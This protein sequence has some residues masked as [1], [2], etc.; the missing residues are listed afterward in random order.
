MSASE[1]STDLPGFEFVIAVASLGGLPV[2]TSLVRGL[3]GTF[4]VP[5]LIVSHRPHRDLDPL[6][7]LLQRQTSLP[8]R[9]AT[10]GLADWGPGITVIP[11]GTA[12][13]L[14]GS[15]RLSLERVTSPRYQC[16][17]ALLASAA[18]AVQPD[19]VIAVVMSGMLRDGA[20]GIRPV[21]RHGGRVLAQDPA[22]ARAASMPNNAIA[23]GCVDFVLPPERLATALVALAMAPGGASL[24]SVPAPHWASLDT[25]RPPVTVTG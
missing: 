1:R 12:A 11:G 10:H 21:K 3:P 6:P 13:T 9:T 14:D 7:W 17:D 15:R 23:T 5:V 25:S 19:A 2:L 24:L 18:G 16:G 4:P 8:V 22:T 20:E